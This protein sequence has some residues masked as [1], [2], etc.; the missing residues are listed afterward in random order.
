TD[1]CP[2]YVAVA[3]DGI[4]VR[5]SPGWMQRRL[6]AA[7][8]RPINSIVDVTNYVML[9][10]GQPQH[11]FDADQLEGG[12]IIV[13]RASEGEKLETIDHQVRQL[14]TEM[15]VIADTAR[16]VGVAGVIGGVT[17]EVSDDTRR[18]VLESANFNMKSVRRTARLLKVRTDASARFERGLDPNL[19]RDAAARATQLI[20]ELSPGAT[21]TAV[22]D[23][24]PDPL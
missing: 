16:P 20:R 4:E 2:R 12:R 9:E 24:Y 3:I 6:R 13:R 8:V 18:I 5:D 11:A 17:S 19:A 23:V 14:D 10:Y 1:L 15:M 21:V 22:A 7:G